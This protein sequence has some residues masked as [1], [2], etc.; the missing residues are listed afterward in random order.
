MIKPQ[1]LEAIKQ[2]PKVEKIEIIEFA[3]RLVREDME[4]PEFSD[5]A[6]APLN[7]PPSTHPHPRKPTANIACHLFGVKLQI[8][9]HIKPLP[10][11]LYL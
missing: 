11:R 3:L 1:I 4:T 10:F 6:H 5:S 2:M 8:A 7:S 9:K